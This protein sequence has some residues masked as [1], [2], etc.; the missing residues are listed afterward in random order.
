MSLTMLKE[1][2]FVFFFFFVIVL[3][4]YKDYKLITIVAQLNASNI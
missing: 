3:Y 4:A 1:N 2:R